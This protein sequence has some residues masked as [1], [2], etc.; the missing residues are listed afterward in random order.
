MEKERET[1]SYVSDAS[2]RAELRKG[3]IMGVNTGKAP[4]RCKSSILG[5]PP[6]GSAQ[7]GTICS[8]I[9]YS[10][11]PGT[12]GQGYKETFRRA[13]FLCKHLLIGLFVEASLLAA[14]QENLESPEAQGPAAK[15]EDSNMGTGV[16]QRLQQS[17]ATE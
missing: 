16:R 7:G 9:F 4:H 1:N 11:F 15:M 12:S 13:H 14:G 5:S 17:A 3:V 2:P 8:N 10:K 6:L